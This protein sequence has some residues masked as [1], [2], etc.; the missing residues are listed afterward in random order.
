[1]KKVIFSSVVAV[2]LAGVAVALSLSQNMWVEREPVKIAENHVA[3]GIYGY[4]RDGKR[5]LFLYEDEHY[6][7]DGAM[8]KWT[9]ANDLESFWDMNSVEAVAYVGGEKAKATADKV[10]YQAI[11]NTF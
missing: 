8:E 10:K 7:H 4:D 11:L 6:G 1:M 5:Q 2:L 3:I 9:D